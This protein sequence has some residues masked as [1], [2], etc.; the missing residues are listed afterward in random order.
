MTKEEF[1]KTVLLERC[2]E[3]GFEEVRWFDL[4][5]WKMKEEFTKTLYQVS[6]TL[7]SDTNMITLERQPMTDRY[8]KNNF[9]PKW[10]F[11]A[12][13]LDEVQKGLVQNPGW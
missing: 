11:S 12:I 1:R 5:R 6:I 9:S 10:Y 2:L 3:F 13:P 7:D 4:V 8:W